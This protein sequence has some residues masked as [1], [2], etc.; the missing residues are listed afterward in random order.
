MNGTRRVARLAAL[1]ALCLLLGNAVPA[2][3]QA[4]QGQDAAGQKPPYTMAEYNSY[5]A[6]EAETNPTQRIKL[7]DDFTSKYPNSAL[8]IYIYPLYYNSYNQ[9]KDW[10]H[11]IESTDKLVALGDKVGPNEKYGALYARAYAYNQLN[12]TDPAQAKSELS[13]CEAG[14]QVI[15]QLKKPDALDE[16]AFNEQ[17]KQ[18]T[19]YLN[20]TCAQAATVLKDYPNVIK[21]DKAVLELNPD[22]AVTRYRLGQA[23]LQMNPPQTLDGYWWV[24]RA[25]TAKTATQQQ[26]TQLKTYLRK[27]IVN[28]QGGTVCDTLTDAELNELLQ[29]AGT[30]ADRPATYKLPSGADLDAVRKDMT[31]LSVV[32]DL[33]GGG[34]KANLTWLAV[35][36]SEFPDVQVKL[37]EV[38]PGTDNVLLK[39]AFVTSDA[40]FQAATTPDMDVKIVGQ[41]DAA[42]LEKDTPVRFTATLVSYDPAPNFMIHWDKGKVNEEDL[43]KPGKP[44]AKRPAAKKPGRSSHQ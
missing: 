43:P 36:G 10:P 37:L 2:F 19:M 42:K 34:D 7:L 13:A 26:S 24:A 22:D 40:E 1:A 8:L 44:A 38:D 9:L 12:S 21:Y 20:G 3:A 11:V 4:A 5:K 23:Y 30:S 31:I 16:N 25:I 18:A 41:P 33:K 39:V 27:L 14:L 15:P 35:C 32:N 6:A 28:Y 17:K 29:L